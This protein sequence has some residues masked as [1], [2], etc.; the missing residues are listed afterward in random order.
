[1]DY[2]LDMYFYQV[3]ELFEENRFQTLLFFFKEWDDPRLSHN[4]SGPMLV[5]DKPIFGKM[6]HP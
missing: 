3:S 1:M 2:Q 5:R 6:W 4:G